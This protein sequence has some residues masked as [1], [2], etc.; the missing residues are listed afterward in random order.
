[1]W[2][3]AKVRYRGLATNTAQLFSLLALSNLYLLR[4]CPRAA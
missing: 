2:G 3:H 4:H 1:M